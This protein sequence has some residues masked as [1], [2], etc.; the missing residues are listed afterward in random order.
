MATLNRRR[1]AKEPFQIHE[2][3]PEDMSDNVNA[4]SEESNAQAHTEV[5]E[6]IDRERT[7]EEEHEDQENHEDEEEHDQEQEQEEDCDSDSSDENEPIDL[8]VQQDMEKL[9][10]AFPDFRDNYRLLKRIGE[11]TALLVA[12]RKC[13]SMANWL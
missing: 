7:E 9:T 3:Q 11:G 4:D 13:E 5:F 6:E 8:T 12:G 2:D 1:V 10:L